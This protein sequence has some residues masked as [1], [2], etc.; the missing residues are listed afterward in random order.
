MQPE[1]ISSVFKILAKPVRKALATLGFSTPTLPQTLAFPPILEG[2][3]VL[4]IAPT[5][6]GKT[7]AVLLPIFS[8]LVE[9]NTREAKGIQVIYVTPLRALNRDMLKRLTF[10]SQQL[11]ITVDLRHGDTEMKIR[12]KQAKKPPQMLVTT[13]ETLQAILPGSQMRRH[14]GNVQTVVIDEVH[15][16]AESKRGIQLTV[17]LERI[18]EATGKD[19]QRIGLSAT[20]GNP[21]EVARFIAGADRECQC[22]AGNSC[23]ELLL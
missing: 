11:D 17:A 20:V 5:G 19:F 22:C 16:L 18:V 9:Q 13:P 15:D 12:R 6:T 10:W 3:N 23:K 2:K 8:K 7:E 14:L 21:E 4:L 1:S